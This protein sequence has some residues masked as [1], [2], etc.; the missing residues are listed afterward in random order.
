MPKGA[1]DPLRREM[2]T[3]VLYVAVVLLATVV[4]IPS[5]DLADD[6]EVIAILWGAAAGLAAAHWFAFH[7]AAQL[8]SGGSVEREDVVSGAAQVAAALGVALVAT[9]PML[10]FGDRV[11]A[12]SAVIVLAGIIAAIGY[13]AS[14]AAGLGRHLAVLRAA[15]TVAAGVVVVAVKVALGH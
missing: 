13:T 5:G 14:R 15:A 6:A 11:G 9:L 2:A 12:G 8:Y 4:A 3:M 7:L 10:L 1:A